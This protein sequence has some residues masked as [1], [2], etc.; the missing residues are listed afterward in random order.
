M[1]R[2]VVVLGLVFALG[3]NALGQGASSLAGLPRSN[4][5]LGTCFNDCN[6]NGVPDETELATGDCDGNGVLDECEM[7]EEVLVFELV[8]TGALVVPELDGSGIAITFSD[9]PN[10]GGYD[11]VEVF[12]DGDIPQMGQAV[13]R[14]THQSN[15]CFD[16]SPP[17]EC[18]SRTQVL[19]DRPGVPLTSFG[20][21]V[22]GFRG[23]LTVKSGRPIEDIDGSDT[24]PP[25]GAGNVE[26]DFLPNDNWCDFEQTQ[27]LTPTLA[28]AT[29]GTYSVRF[30]DVSPTQ[31]S[32][33]IHE[34]RI[35]F[36]DE[37]PGGV[38]NDCDGDGL[39][40]ACDFTCGPWEDQ[41]CALAGITS[42]PVLT[43]M[44]ALTGGS[45]NQVDL[46]NAAPSATAGLFLA[47]GPVT[48]AAFKGGTLKPIPFLIDPVILNTN[49]AGEIPIPFVMPPGI[50]PGTELWIQ[51]AIQDAA[52]VK[53]VALSNAI[54]GTTP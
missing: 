37:V 48:P 40:D 22:N 44:G 11:R 16:G 53:G 47:L 38:V 9:T 30:I 21:S 7:Q 33:T 17:T 46:T 41:G 18:V 5:P 12:I 28:D 19:I 34:V 45:A 52:A 27:Q 13:V 51:W 39:L 25:G 31:P 54:L 35:R 15:Q 2:I 4:E 49:P 43:A 50:P 20:T 36:L 26:G 6:G 3:P 24:N 23:T 1:L 10:F 32:I 42:D 14:L 8:W 29:G